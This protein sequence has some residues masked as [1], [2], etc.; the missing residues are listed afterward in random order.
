MPKK[1]ILGNGKA[2]MCLERL[3]QD[4]PIPDTNGAMRE[5]SGADLTGKGALYATDLIFDILSLLA[6][7]SFATIGPDTL[8]RISNA[9]HFTPDLSVTIGKLGGSRQSSSIR[10]T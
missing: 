5:G 9:L 3:D 2:R 7:G 6:Q 4:L 10:S 8:D 1:P